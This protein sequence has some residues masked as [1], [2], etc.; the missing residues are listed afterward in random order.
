MS[1]FSVGQAFDGRFS[2]RARPAKYLVVGAGSL[3]SSLCYGPSA[4]A[5]LGAGICAATLSSLCRMVATGSSILSY[6][7]A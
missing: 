1:A 7:S 4:A 2:H 3:V 6:L 5:E